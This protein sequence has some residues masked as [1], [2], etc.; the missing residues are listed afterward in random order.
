M[1][2][3]PSKRPD[4]Q[5][6]DIIKQ[7]QEEYTAA[8]ADARIS[9][10]HTQTDGWQKL[11]GNERR[12]EQQTR[13]R[14]CGELEQAA[15]RLQLVG[16][17]EDDEKA[18]AEIKKGMTAMRERRDSFDRTTVAP[19]KEPVDRCERVAEKFSSSAKYAEQNA[20]LHNVGLEH[21]MRDAIAGC[22]KASW[23]E[24]AGRVEL[25]EA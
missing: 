11:Y 15:E 20:P 1:S 22:P 8:I 16:S 3:E 18:L 21:L 14:L 5:K 17:T 9:E 25:S 6:I 23:N 4:N 10:E 13:R 24:D 19:V 2:A 12:D 7:F